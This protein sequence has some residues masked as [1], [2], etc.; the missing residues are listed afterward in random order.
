MLAAQEDGLVQ[1]VDGAWEG[2][3]KWNSTFQNPVKG[4]LR[5]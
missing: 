3:D 4:V 5:R 2:T 1:K